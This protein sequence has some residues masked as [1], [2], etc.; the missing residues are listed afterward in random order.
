MQEQEYHTY[1]SSYLSSIRL[2]LR[3]TKGDDVNQVKRQL[4]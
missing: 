1:I 4:D 3:G 2:L